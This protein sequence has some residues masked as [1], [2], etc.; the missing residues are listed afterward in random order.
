[1]KKIRQEYGEGRFWEIGILSKKE[2]EEMG[3]TYYWLIGFPDDKPP[4]RILLEAQ[5]FG[6]IRRFIEKAYWKV[7]VPNGGK[8]L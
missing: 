2:Q 1:M 3:E 6:A 4:I 8:S 5:D 7:V